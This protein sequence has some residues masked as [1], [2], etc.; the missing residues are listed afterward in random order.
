MAMTRKQ[1]RL[2][3]IA[4]AGAVLTVAAGLILF[5]LSDKIVFFYTPGDIAKQNIAAGSRVRIGGLVENGSVIR[6][7][8]MNVIFRVTD[9]ETFLTVH[10]KGLL[11]DLFR[12]GQGVVAEGVYQGNSDVLAD[13]VLAKHDENY[14]PKDVADALKKKGVWQGGKGQ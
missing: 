3:L 12:E 14:M 6:D 8:S 10:Y 1:K 9:T 4:S 7:A 2:A 13:T 5:A 11:P